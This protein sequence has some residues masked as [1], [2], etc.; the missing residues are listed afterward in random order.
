[1]IRLGDIIVQGDAQQE[2]GGNNMTD[3]DINKTAGS[4]LGIA[5][6]GIDIGLL[7]HTAKNVSRM[8]DDMYERRPLVKRTERRT[9]K[10]PAK[11]NMYENYW[12]TKK[13]YW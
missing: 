13:T 6:M 8:T 4:V 1:M 2:V 11:R 3:F 7:A 5:G 12:G 9:Y 10:K